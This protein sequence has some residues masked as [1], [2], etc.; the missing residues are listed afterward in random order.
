MKIIFFGTPRFAQIVLEKLID[1]PFRP[2]IVVTATDAK[3]GRGQKLKSS[4]VKQTAIQKG[5]RILQPHKLSEISGQLKDIDIAIL[6]A[7]GK[8]IPKEILAIP[9]FGFV[10]VHPSLLPKYRGP[11]PI[12][13]AILAGEKKNGVSIILLDE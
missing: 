7:Y 6:V 11:S 12:Q 8:I 1:S 4:P 10:N 3:F 13:S 5:L 9:K 2:S